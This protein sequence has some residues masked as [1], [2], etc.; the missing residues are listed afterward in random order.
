MT[1]KKRLSQKEREFFALVTQA[2]SA[3]PFSD[4]RVEIDLKLSGLSPG[5]S[6]SE[7]IAKLAEEVTARIKVPQVP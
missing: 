7:R 3:N 6:R 1:T 2:I 5:V 4:E